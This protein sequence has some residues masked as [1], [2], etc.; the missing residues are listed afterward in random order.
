M[1]LSENELSCHAIA[2]ESEM[3][4]SHTADDILRIS[5]HILSDKRPEMS[6]LYHISRNNIGR[7]DG[8]ITSDTGAYEVVPCLA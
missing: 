4:P 1:E 8:S 7:H 6:F 5:E 3:D 2:I